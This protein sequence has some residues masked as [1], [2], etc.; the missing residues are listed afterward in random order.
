MINLTLWAQIFIRFALRTAVS[1]I[2]WIKVKKLAYFGLSGPDLRPLERFN[3]IQLY[4][5][6]KSP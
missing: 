1:E 5:Q 6:S 3:Q 4:S 2:Q